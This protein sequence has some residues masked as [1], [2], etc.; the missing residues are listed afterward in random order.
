MLPPCIL[1]ALRHEYHQHDDVRQGSYAHGT[2]GEVNAYFQAWKNP[3][4][5]WKTHG[6]VLRLYMLTFKY[7]IRFLKECRTEYKP[8][9]A[10]SFLRE[11]TL[12]EKTSMF[13]SFNPNYCVAFDCVT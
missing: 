5:L 8:A 2:P 10:L 1:K 13:Y 11:R 4:R 6:N 7:L 3:K 12:T 9:F